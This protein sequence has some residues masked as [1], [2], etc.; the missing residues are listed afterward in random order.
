[1]SLQGIESRRNQSLKDYTSIKIGGIAKNIFI[2][3]DADELRGVFAECGSDVYVLGRGSNIL[4]SDG[5]IETPV[6]KLGKEFSFI[7]EDDGLMDIGGATPLSLALQYCLSKDLAGLH[8]LAGIPASIGGMAVMNA[9]AYGRDMYSLLDKAE[10]MDKQGGISFIEKADIKSAYRWTS[11][12]G[13]IVL[14][15]RLS[16]ER[17]K[18]IKAQMREF[19][20]RR[21]QSQDFSRPSCGCIFKN[22]VGE[23]AGLLIEKCGLKGLRRGEAQVSL[24]HANFIVNMGQASCNDVD[25]LIQKIKDTVNVR[26]GIILEEEIERWV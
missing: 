21:M 2:V 22:P 12:R 26:C 6:I 11:L 23:S 13:Q 10:V 19:L 3:R 24:K 16:L 20:G 15:V 17:D 18:N 9:S 1:M 25:Y 7:R 4:V 14:S 5:I 8:N